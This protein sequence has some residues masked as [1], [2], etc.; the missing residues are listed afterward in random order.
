MDKQSASRE[1]V[2]LDKSKEPKHE[3]L[4]TSDLNEI[5]S[6]N[7]TSAIYDERLDISIDLNDEFESKSNASSARRR[8]SVSY[9]QPNTP[10]ARSLS[11]VSDVSSISDLS[12][13]YLE[14]CTESTNSES[15]A[16]LNSMNSSAMSAD[17]AFLQ[18]HQHPISEDRIEILDDASKSML[19][20]SKKKRKKKKKD[21]L[22]KASSYDNTPKHRRA[23]SRQISRSRPLTRRNSKDCMD[24]S[25][26]A[27][28]ATKSIELWSIAEVQEWLKII[29]SGKYKEYAVHFKSKK[30]DGKRLYKLNRQMLQSMGI[31]HPGARK[32]IL[33]A[34]QKLKSRVS[35]LSLL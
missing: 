29:H 14:S 30:I 1:E 22:I 9:S 11:P 16:S 33:A 7:L 6:Q 17:F 8:S 25:A 23:K 32:G 27:R 13:E 26:L 5:I 10:R 19:E 24:I 35:R 18:F 15:C 12:T 20:P 28:L 2:D 21:R 34:L 3:R 31:Y 4:S